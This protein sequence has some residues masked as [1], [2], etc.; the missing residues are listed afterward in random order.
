[1]MLPLRR[2]CWH[3]ATAAIKKQTA[4]PPASVSRNYVLSSWS[5]CGIC[6]L[7][8]RSNQRQPAASFTFLPPSLASCHLLQVTSESKQSKKTGTVS[9]R[10][11]DGQAANQNI[12]NSPNDL[13]WLRPY[14]LI[15]SAS[16][17]LT[18][19]GAGEMVP[20][21]TNSLQTT[22]MRPSPPLVPTCF[23]FEP[24]R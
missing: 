9:P 14:L 7:G 22:K 20:L 16:C 23:L 18:T 2:G 3:S 15:C 19:T 21:L 4:V 5:I 24:L 11:A 10:Q 8:T 1:M 6:Q 12:I 17:S 13:I